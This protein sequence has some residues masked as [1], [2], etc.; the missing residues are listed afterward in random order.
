MKALE[1]N[2]KKLPVPSFFQIFNFGGGVADKSREIVYAD[3]TYNTPALIN[4]KNLSKYPHNFSSPYFNNATEL[5]DRVGNL[6]NYIRIQ[7]I[8]KGNV[9]IKYDIPNFDF[10]DKIMMLDS[11]SFNIVKFVAKSVGYDINLFEKEIIKHA[12]SYYCFAHK[13]KFDIVVSF[14][15]GGKYTFKDGEKQDKDL[16]LFLKNLDD[17]R[18]NNI[19]LRETAKFVLN[20]PNF[21]PK[22]L[23][24]VHGFSPN[25]YKNNIRNILYIEKEYKMTI[26]GILILNLITSQRL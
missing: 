26:L 4:R 5:F 23:A 2:G 25:D 19:L 20:H 3:M 1:I 7:L 22:I 16:Q 15:L 13:L 10:N 21:Y 11:G 12:L 6:Y 14:D 9:Y 24:T 18:I 8:E 17:D